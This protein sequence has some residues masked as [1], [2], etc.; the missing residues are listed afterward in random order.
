[1]GSLTLGDDGS[2]LRWRWLHGVSTQEQQRFARSLINSPDRR[3]G[4]TAFGRSLCLIKNLERKV[5]ELRVGF[6]AKA[7]AQF[8]QAT[9]IAVPLNL[10]LTS[11]ISKGR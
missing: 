8:E 5:T 11:R 10:N 1:M 6:S 7:V 2:R 3:Y 9:I 4:E